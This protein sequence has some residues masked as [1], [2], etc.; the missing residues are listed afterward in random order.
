M[1]ERQQA[2]TVTDLGSKI[3]VEGDCSHEK[4]LGPWKESKTNL[5][6]VFKPETTLC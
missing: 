6:S 1:G 3:T 5:H 4:T 2:E